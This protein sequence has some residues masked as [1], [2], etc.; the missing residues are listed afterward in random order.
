MRGAFSKFDFTLKIRRE[1]RRRK[2]GCL[3]GAG[4]LCYAPPS[5]SARCYSWMPFLRMHRKITL[6]RINLRLKNMAMK[7]CERNLL[8]KLC[9]IRYFTIFSTNLSKKLKPEYQAIVQLNKENRRL[10]GPLLKPKKPKSNRKQVEPILKPT[11][12]ND[13]EASRNSSKRN[14]NKNTLL[15]PLQK[16]DLL[17]EDF[18][19]NPTKLNKDI[20]SDSS[21]SNKQTI[22]SECD[23]K[24]LPADWRAIITEFIS[25]KRLICQSE[26]AVLDNTCYKSVLDS[27]IDYKVPSVTG[28]LQQTLSPQNRLILQRWKDKMIKQL[29]YENFM[30]YQQDLKSNGINFHNFIQNL[31]NKTIT[32]SEVSQEFEAHWKSLQNVLPLINNTKAVESYMTHQS[33]LYSGVIDCIGSYNDAVYVIDWKTSQ[34]PK[35]FL[36]NTYDNPIQLAAYIGAFNACNPYEEQLKKGLIIIVYP[37]GSP[38]DVHVMDEESCQHYWKKWQAR[39]CQYWISLG[40]AKQNSGTLT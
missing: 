3:T 29:G 37:N 7:F 26:D 18:S 35:P 13:E 32:E 23:S 10:F 33:L 2:L 14:L 20:S 11:L 27:L 40:E 16:N 12:G 4:L 9:N 17:C 6:N 34:K 38:A 19:E 39:L 21:D 36:K 31:L 30:K 24:A 8:I 1:I 15:K 22:V 28:I 5:D 25:S